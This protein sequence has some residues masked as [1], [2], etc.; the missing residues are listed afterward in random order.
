MTEGELGETHTN[1]NDNKLSLNGHYKKIQR[2]IRKLRNIVLLY[3]CKVEDCKC[4]IPPRVL[5]SDC[6]II[7]L[8]RVNPLLKSHWKLKSI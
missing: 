1:L 4:L 2:N 6:S 8:F 7:L 5:L 3:T